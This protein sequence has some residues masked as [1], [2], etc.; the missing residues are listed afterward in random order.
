M[1]IQAFHSQIKKITTLSYDNN[2]KLLFIGNADGRM[3][4]YEIEDNYKNVNF[5]KK[6]E[7]LSQMGLKV[8][9]K[10]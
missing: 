10:F 5:N 8:F 2:L 6:L 7:V 1:V 3:T 4:A 9:S